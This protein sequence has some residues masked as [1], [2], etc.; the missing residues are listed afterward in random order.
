MVV[1]SKLKYIKPF[2]RICIVR[3]NHSLHILSE[4]GV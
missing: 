4:R 2:H 3:R 1:E